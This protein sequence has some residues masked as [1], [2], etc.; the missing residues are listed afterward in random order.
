MPYKQEKEHR[1][2]IQKEL[3][4]KEKESF[5]SNL[6][7]EQEL[8]IELFDYLDTEL[9]SS[10]CKHDYN[11]T[12]NFLNSKGKHLEDRVI[13][14]FQEQRGYCDCEILLNVEEKFE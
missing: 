8:L 14:W 2:Q 9:A 7:M 4:R 13:K 6:P 10:G 5:F 3:A 11:L 1:K 12:S